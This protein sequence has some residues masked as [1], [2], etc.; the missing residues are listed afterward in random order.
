MASANTSYLACSTPGPTINTSPLG[1]ASLSLLT[2][3]DLD[4]STTTKGFERSH[5]RCCW[6]GLAEHLTKTV[7]NQ[8]C[9]DE[10]EKIRAQVKTD[11]FE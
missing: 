6:L 3:A 4:H 10:L 8:L 5:R 1:T 11:I 7:R 2:E 9:T